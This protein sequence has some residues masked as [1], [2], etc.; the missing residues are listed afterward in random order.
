MKNR[1]NQAK[2]KRKAWSRNAVRK[3]S[4]LRIARGQAALAELKSPIHNQDE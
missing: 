2:Q 4:A 3:K 1:F